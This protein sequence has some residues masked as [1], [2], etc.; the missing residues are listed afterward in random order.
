MP[1]PDAAGMQ[2]VRT[3]V[4]VHEFILAFDLLTVIAAKGDSAI[5]E[6]ARGILNHI[7][8]RIGAKPDNWHGI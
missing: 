7:A 2:Q 5:S 3:F 8:E 6:D 1:N 4:N